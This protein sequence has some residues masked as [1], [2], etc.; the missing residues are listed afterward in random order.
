MSKS[1][2]LLAFTLFFVSAI[3]SQNTHAVFAWGTQELPD[4]TGDAQTPAVIAGTMAIAEI[5]DDLGYKNVIG[6]PSS[7]HDLPSLYSKCIRIGN[8]MKPD[9]ETVKMLNADLYLASLG[10]KPALDKI[11][12]N[13]SIKVEYVALDS[14]EAALHSIK[15]I[16][17]LTSKEK[18][19]ARVIQTIETKALEVRRSISGKKSPKVLMILGSPKRLM[20]GT[21]NCYTG[22]LMRLLKIHN[23]ADD[24]GN[25][26]K[27]Y[28]PINIEE[29]IKHR[30][31]VIIRLTHTRPEDT[32]AALR[33]EFAGSR[34]WREV[35]AVKEGKIYDLDSA[36]YIVSRNIKIMF[37]IE[38]L[39][40]L[41]YDTNGAA[42]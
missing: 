38:N 42:E 18:E 1:R 13:Q 11:F 3:F 34:I 32:A 20:M 24:I 28:V 35:K 19:A 21:K 16:G 40:E 37:A 22:S 33:K 31:D 26:D 41:I 23:I 15:R 14:Y 10:S 30:P 27:P 2:C 25:F 6:V 12:I 29:I 9:I 39:K 8:P 36:L 4:K 17:T 7:R 5:L